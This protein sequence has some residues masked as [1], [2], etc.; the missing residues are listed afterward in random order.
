M[1]IWAFQ[2]GLPSGLLHALREQPFG[3]DGE[4]DE[5]EE[6]KGRRQ[7]GPPCILS[8]GGGRRRRRVGG[9]RGEGKEEGGNR[10]KERKSKYPSLRGARGLIGPQKL[11]KKN[12]RFLLGPGCCWGCCVVFV[13][14]CLAGKIIDFVGRNWRGR[15]AD[16]PVELMPLLVV[17]TPR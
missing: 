4:I 13:P 16:R 7:R 14:G 2:S 17:R 12:R 1:V 11:K 3:A 5:E 8:V 6:G 9:R 15:K 10:R